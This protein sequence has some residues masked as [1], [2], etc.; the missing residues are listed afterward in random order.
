MI[1]LRLESMRSMTRFAP[2]ITKTAVKKILMIVSG[3]EI[4]RNEV[5]SLVN[6]L[7]VDLTD[8]LSY[9]PEEV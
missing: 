7:S 5:L 8:E 2:K 1:L 9:I 6:I 4:T 3:E